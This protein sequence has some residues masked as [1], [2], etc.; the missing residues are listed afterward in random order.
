MVL[1]WKKLKTQD[2]WQML[3]VDE[4][5]LLKNLYEVSC[6]AC[7]THSRPGLHSS[8][9]VNISMERDIRDLSSRL[10]FPAWNNFQIFLLFI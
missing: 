2:S 10:R 8:H 3:C 5:F 4:M 9:E 6:L 7:R 1:S